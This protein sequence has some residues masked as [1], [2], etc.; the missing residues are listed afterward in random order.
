MELDRRRRHIGRRS[1]PPDV[2][3]RLRS[4]HLRRQRRL[5]QH[6]ASR[7]WRPRPG[8]SGLGADQQRLSL[9]PA[10]SLARRCPPDPRQNQCGAAGAHDRQGAR[11]QLRAAAIASADPAT[12][13]PTDGARRLELDMLVGRVRPDARAQ[14]AADH[15]AGATR[16]AELTSQH[17][18]DRPRRYARRRY[19][20]HAECGRPRGAGRD[21]HQFV[22]R[23]SPLRAQSRHPGH[24]P[25]SEHP[26]CA[27]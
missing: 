8:G 3:D 22:C 15:H 17:L 25:Y 24:R 14:R 1:R 26:A 19:R 20:P 4:V 23:H 6:L 16:H 13:R 10:R 18:V 5:G 21:V 27:R 2:H 12:A 7:V 9:Q 11:T